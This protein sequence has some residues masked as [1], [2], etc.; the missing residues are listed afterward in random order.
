MRTTLILFI[1]LS[2]AAVVHADEKPKPAAAVKEIDL[3]Q[4]KG[5]PRG[6]A[7]E[8]TE[9]KSAKDLAKA[10]EDEKVRAAIAR[11]VDFANQKLVYFAWAGSGQDKLTVAASSKE[12]EVVFQYRRGLTRDL[13]GHRHLFALPK[14]LTWTFAMEK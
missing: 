14:N 5:I 10:F 11:Q 6:K 9:I 1:A 13:R 2:L 12:G 3:G 4:I 8:P 7:G